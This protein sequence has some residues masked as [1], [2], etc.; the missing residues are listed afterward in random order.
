MEKVDPHLSLFQGSNE[1]VSE[2]TIMRVSLDK[3]PR[4]LVRAPP[5]YTGA[6][7]RYPCCTGQWLSCQSCCVDISALLKRAG[8]SA[9]IWGAI[10]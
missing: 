4:T 8:V 7:V 10:I 5:S 6:S 2:E 1:D 9:G 3:D